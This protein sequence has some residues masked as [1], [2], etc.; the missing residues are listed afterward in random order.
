MNRDDRWHRVPAPQTEHRD[1]A[2]EENAGEGAGQ[3]EAGGVDV[4]VCEEEGVGADE[5][6][7][8]HQ[9]ADGQEDHPGLLYAGVAHADQASADK[10]KGAEHEERHLE[11][12]ADRLI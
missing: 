1:G 10:E 8:H 9:R 2:V 5:V 3:P 7:R 12:V 11:A 6:E 4:F